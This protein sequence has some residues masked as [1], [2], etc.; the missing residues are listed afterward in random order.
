[1]K[2][3]F[4][5]IIT[6]LCCTLNNIYSQN[7]AYVKGKSYE[8]YIFPKEALLGNPPEK[9]R[10]TLSLEDIAMAEKILGEYM[11][12]NKNREIPLPKNRRALKK[13]TRQYLGYLSSNNEIIIR[14]NLFDKRKLEDGQSPSTETIPLLGYCCIQINITTNKIGRWEE[15]K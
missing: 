1:M 3:I 7:A 6:L 4:L 13:F 2:R 9:N 5:I 8:G 12:S 10:Y 11:K 14:I 15:I